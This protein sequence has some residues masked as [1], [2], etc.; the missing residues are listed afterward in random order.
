M[1]FFKFRRNSL[2]ML[3]KVTETTDTGFVEFA[4]MFS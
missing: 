2:L 3:T 4:Q 1:K